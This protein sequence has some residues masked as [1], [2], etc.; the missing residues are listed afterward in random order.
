MTKI[1]KIFEEEWNHNYFH[2]TKGFH[3]YLPKKNSLNYTQVFS[4]LCAKL[5]TLEQEVKF[6]DTTYFS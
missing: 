5:K 3:T 4:T 2:T 6:I 1:V